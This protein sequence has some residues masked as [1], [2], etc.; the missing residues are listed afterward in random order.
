MNET[1]PALRAT[2]TGERASGD[3]PLTEYELISR[4]PVV[5]AAKAL[6]K[7]DQRR[8]DPTITAEEWVPLWEAARLKAIAAVDALDSGTREGVE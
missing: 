3:A 2:Q 4:L 7:H 6:L 8:T 1:A 5:E